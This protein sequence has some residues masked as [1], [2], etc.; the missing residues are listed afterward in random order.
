MKNG[1][2]QNQQIAV[3][4]AGLSGSAAALLLSSEGADVT[5]L[6]SLKTSK[7]PFEEQQN[8]A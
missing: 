3:L 7:M 2:Y 1:R 6:D 4:G 5:V 8:T